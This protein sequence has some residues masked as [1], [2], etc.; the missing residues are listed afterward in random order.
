MLTA[1]EE[2]NSDPS[3]EV[4]DLDAA[5][6]E[7]AANARRPTAV[8]IAKCAECGRRGSVGQRCL[9]G[10][11]VH[12]LAAAQSVLVALGASRWAWVPM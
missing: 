6:K 8:S 10:Q 5:M 3:N 1:G 11:G 12:A 9:C 2:E 4:F 7:I